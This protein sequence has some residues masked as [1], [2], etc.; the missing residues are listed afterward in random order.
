MKTRTRFIAS[1][2]AIA[3]ALPESMLL[4]DCAASSSSMP[5]TRKGMPSMYSS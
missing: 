1:L 3:A 2:A 4:T 5:A